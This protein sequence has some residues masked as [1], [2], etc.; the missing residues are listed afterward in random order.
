VA[1]AELAVILFPYLA[2]V[3]LAA[4]FSAALQVRGRFLE[5]ALNPVW[6]NVSMLGL[7]AVGAW[8]AAGDPAGQMRW[9][10]AGV[11]LGGVAQVLGPGLA[12]WRLGAAPGLR[13]SWSA[14]VRQIALLMVPTLFSSAIY[15]VNA[16]LSRLFALS[17]DDAAATVLNLSTRLMELPIGV[18]ALAVA[19]VYFPKIARH[20]AEGRAE[21]LAADYRQGM[22]MILLVNVPAAVGLATLAEPI[23]RVL[24]ERGA[25][26]AADTATMA[27]VLALSALALPALAFVS[28]ALRVFHAHKDMATPVRAA[29]LS[30]G[31]NVVASLALMRVLGVNG[32]A[33]ASTLAVLAQAVFLQSRLKRRDQALGSGHLLGHLGKVGLAAL[34]MG[35]ALASGGTALAAALAARVP[36]WARVAGEAIGLGLAIGLAVL[37]YA[38]AVWALR[39][40]GRDE[41]LALVRR[42][43]G[44]RGR[45]AEA[46][47]GAGVP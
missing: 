33:L 7:L 46:E 15:V 18:F 21:E 28:L 13:L 39:V 29:A 4:V 10:C 30:F 44:R 9:L 6:L 22:R 8:R 25:F 32:L 12:L 1:G 19:T 34:L 5:P 23:T 17:V 36:D 45:A 20:A 24:F 42:K 3:C 37:L 11:L 35:V 47:K 14:P 16:S 2:L 38:A 43:L 41:A 26:T 40:E 27:P 31:V